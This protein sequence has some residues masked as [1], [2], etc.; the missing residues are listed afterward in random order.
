M[1]GTSPSDH[2]HPEEVMAWAD[3]ETVAGDVARHVATCV[4]CQALAGDVRSV[5][6]RLAAWSVEPA[7]FQMPPGRT[8]PENQWRYIGMAALLVIGLLAWSTVHEWKSSTT[9]A[10]DVIAQPVREDRA[11]FER[12]WAARPRVDVSVP[13]DGASVVVVVFI[14]W[15]CPI[16]TH[17]DY[18]PVIAAY[19]AAK[20]GVV[21]YVVKDYPLNAKCNS[22]VRGNAPHAAACEAAAAVRMAR[23]RGT[24]DEFIDWIFSHQRDLTPDRVKAHATSSLGVKDFDAE[25]ARKL[26]DIQ[27]DVADATALHLQFTPTV[28]VNG[29]LASREGGGSPSAQQLDWAI[30][31]ELKRAGR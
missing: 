30:Q 24:A 17:L 27:R 10:R 19:E 21:R 12:D 23:D 7:S 20:P 28:F 9:P 6:T 18:A 11:V 25:Y 13:A 16:C 29:V 2:P 26:T 14:D 4:H 3:G 31:Y 22:N 1:T 5:R 15:Q 8:I